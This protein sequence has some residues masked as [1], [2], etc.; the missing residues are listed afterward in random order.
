[1]FNGVIASVSSWSDMSI[2]VKVPSSATN[3][4]VT[5]TEDAVV[6]NS[7]QFTVLERL[8]ITGLSQTSETVG[9]S[10]TIT[11]TGFGPT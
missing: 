4:P 1:M 2:T 6:S 8:T 11:G 10:I 3:G 9:G 7:L 5:V